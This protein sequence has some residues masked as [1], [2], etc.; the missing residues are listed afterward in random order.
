MKYVLALDEGTT[1]ARAI[2]FDEEARETASHA[3]PI[4]SRYPQSGW[5]EQDADEIWRRQIEAARG[6]IDKAGLRAA[7]IAAIGITNQRETTVVWDRQSGET[8]GPA[9]VWQCRRTADV[10]RRLAEQGHAERIAERTGLV[11][12]AYFS[13]TKIGWILDH[14]PGARERAE[15]GELAFGTIDSW[16]IYKL[17]G[18]TQHVIDFSNASRT[19]LLNLRTG[20]WDDEMLKLFNVPKSM[21]P[22]VVPSSGVAATSR[23][24]LLGEE[25]P[26]AGIAGDQQAALFGQACFR[27][28]L[29]K[30]TYGTGCFL[31]MHT[32]AEPVASRNRLIGTIASSGGNGREY[33]LEGSIFIAGAVVQWLRDALGM[34]ENSA[35]SEE[36]ANAV[37]DTGGVY[38]VPAFVGLGAPYWDA[39]ARG[40]LTGLTQASR[41]EHIVRAGLES[42]AYQTRELADAMEADAGMEIVELRADG[43]AAV[44]NFLM[45]FQADILGKPVVRP[46][47]IET[48]ALGAAFL[49]GLAA[50]VW[51][52]TAELEQFWKADRVFEPRM[53]AA[54]REELLSGWKR[55]VAKARGA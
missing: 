55:A 9:I 20:Q 2:V 18:G 23:A 42:I 54:Q 27:R 48:T 36:A 45:Q 15:A 47:Y 39:D 51:K 50:G 37:A 52:D 46:A 13:G 7:D 5:V 3:L 38:L 41:R 16:L 21:L 25:I 19:L 31:L 44:N 28:G 49:A 24:E 4:E 32:G 40:I 35:Q 26:I 6:A 17:T 22:K 43:G 10:C 8:V 11:I 30:N 53:E 29:S 1:S 34:L 12:D 33:A 14:V